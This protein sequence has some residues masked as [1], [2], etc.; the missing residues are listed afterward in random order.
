MRGKA[1][2]S[3]LDLFGYFLGQLPKSNRLAAGETKLCTSTK[4]KIKMDSGF[5]RN[6]ELKERAASADQKAPVAARDERRDV[7]QQA[8]HPDAARVG[9]V[10]AGPFRLELVLV[11]SYT[12][13]IV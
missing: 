3:A 10:G 2:R 1:P 7:D 9:Q 13:V 8:W 6:D 11:A 5:R 4:E 12:L